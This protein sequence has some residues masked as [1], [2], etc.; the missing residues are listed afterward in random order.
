MHSKPKILTDIA[1]GQSPLWGASTELIQ[2]YP[3]WEALVQKVPSLKGATAQSLGNFIGILRELGSYDVVINANLK[4]A[5]LF[6]FF[7]SLLK[8][9]RPRHIILEVMLDE[10]RAGFLWNAKRLLQRFIFSSVD[11]IFV[12]ATREIE[13]YSNRFNLPREKFRF[14][15]FHTDIVRP[16][17]IERRDGYIL[18]AG[19][20]GRDY[21]TLA[22]AVRGLDYKVV[23][24]SDAY[25]ARGIRFPEN[26]DL[27][28]DIPYKQYRELLYGCDFVVVPLQ[29]LVK[30][31]GQ[32][33]LLEAMSVGKPVIA[34]DTVGT[35]DYIDSGR[36]GLLVP[37]GD[38]P[39]LRAA[40][41]QLLTDEALYKRI[42]LNAFEDV[43]E[44]YTFDK[45]TSSIIEA[46]QALV[47]KS[48]AASPSS[49]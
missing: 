22:E 33:A 14:H 15:P 19:K 13:L 10:D 12:S 34:T 16:R 21:A 5:Q 9:P 35:I 46:A 4:T 31:T 28:C 3:L 6:G 38:P 30:S 36:N 37:A 1:I 44:K 39:A 20:T 24:V 11:I 25:S 18:S 42:A 40:I 49:F 2:R 29:K 41:E 47:E 43:L 32:V 26:V 45:Y 7:R 8:I 17:L 48:E 27:Y 23:V